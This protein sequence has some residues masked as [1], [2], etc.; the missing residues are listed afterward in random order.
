MLQYLR[1][2]TGSWIIKIILGLIVVVFIFLGMG[3]LG[4]KQGGPVATVD[5]E[6]ISLDEYKESYSR[7]KQEMRQRFGGNLNQEV[8]DML[9]LKQQ[10]MNRIVNRKLMAR[11]AERLGITVSKRELR[12]SLT[13]IS[14][15]QDNGT[16]SMDRYKQVL[17]ANRMTPESFEASQRE[18]LKQEKLRDLVVSSIAVSTPEAEEWYKYQNTRVSINYLAFDPDSYKDIEP[19]SQQVKEFYEDN[20]ENY[21][22]EEKLLVD[23]IGFSPEDYA[24]DVE[25]KDSELKRYYEKNRAEYEVPEKVEASHIL[26][27]TEEDADRESIEEAEKRAVEVYEKAV[28]EKD[29]AELAKQYSEGP[30]AEE[31][32]YLGKFEKDSMVKP[33]AEKAFS[34]SPGDI[35]RPVKTRFG[36]HIIKVTDRLEASVESFEEVKDDI[37]DRIIKTRISDHAY[38]AAGDAFDAVIEGDSLEQAALLTDRKVKTAGPFTSQG[39][40]LDLPAASEFASEAFSC[41]I[42]EISDVKQ[43]GNTY[44]LIKPVKRIPPKIRD[45][46]SV[47]HEAKADLTFR[48]RKEAAEKGAEK[49]LESLKKGESMKSASGEIQPEMKTTGLFKRQ[50][51]IEGIGTSQEVSEA[52]FK[53]TM[54][55]KVC[56]K[57]LKSEDL[58]YVIELAQK[59]VPEVL[60]KGGE[61]AEI[62][63]SILSKKE[64]AAYADWLESLKS[65]YPVKIKSDILDS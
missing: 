39:K 33:F 41:I 12:D 51:E 38:Y 46:E 19:S 2:N 50:G 45:F 57:V 22:T 53:L 23:Y 5:D 21:K 11:E 36:W 47:R 35:S 10:A 32:G 54:D 63:S 17:A 52:A 27:R 31:G 14:V 20:K 4:S 61:M 42:D 60:K 9:N 7:L 56:P 24:D 44:Y 18:S 30:S 16:F 3:S 6:S 28:N 29:F 65:R 25:V 59:E 13:A 1:D 15:F 26:I 48:L 55:Q 37:K 8:M 40:G 43:I 64:Q 58:F 49:I 62:K 34:M